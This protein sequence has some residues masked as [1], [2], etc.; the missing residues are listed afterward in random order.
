[1]TT[2]VGIDADLSNEAQQTV[3]TWFQIGWSNP[4]SIT[5]KLKN[6]ENIEGT[7]ASDRIVG[8]NTDNM[9]SGCDGND[10][11]NGG[12]GDDVIYTGSGKDVIL[13]GDGDDKI[14]VQHTT[15]TTARVGVGRYVYIRKNEGVNVY[16]SLAELQVISNGMNVSLGKTANLKNSGR[17]YGKIWQGANLVD[18]KTG[19]NVRTDGIFSSSSS[20]DGWIQVDLGSSIA[21]DAINIFGRSDSLASENGNYTVYVSDTDMAG[22]T[23]TQLKAMANVGFVNVANTVDWVTLQD[24]LSVTAGTAST[25]ML[26]DSNNASNALAATGRY[27]YIRKNA[28]V[29]DYLSLA[30]LEVMS[31][32]VNVAR[33]KTDF[34][35]KSGEFNSTNHAAKNVVDGKSSGSPS[36]DG[37]FASNAAG[38]GWIQVDLGLSTA[39]DAINIFG[40]TDSWASQNGNYTVYVSDTDMAGKTDAELKTMAN[41]AYYNQSLLQTNTTIFAAAM[42]ATSGTRGNFFTRYLISD[43]KNID[44][45]AGNDVVSYK[46]SGPVGMGI[47]A[48]LSPERQTV[49]TGFVNGVANALSVTDTL[50]SIE[51]IEG[52]DWNDKLLGS[53]Q[54]NKLYGAGGADWIDGGAGD[55]ELYTGTGADTVWGGS[56]DD[57]IRVQHT[58]LLV[59]KGRYVYIRKNDGV[60]NYLSLGELE[61]MSNGVNVALG[62][63]SNLQKSGEY[64]PTN[65]AA[66]NLVDGKSGGNGSVDGIFASNTAGGG[67]IQVDLGL[68]TAI[69]AINIFGRTDSWATQ[70]GNYTV[71]VSDTDMAG[72][73]DAELKTMANVGFY[74]ENKVISSTSLSVPLFTTVGTSVN[75]FRPFWSSLENKIIDGGEGSDTVSY[76]GMQNAV[77]M[78]ITANLSTA[79]QTVGVWRD[80]RNDTNSTSALVGKGRYVYI[81]KNEGV[82]DYLSLAELQVMSNGVN[83]ALGKT[84]NLQKSGEYNR[85]NHAAVNLVDGTTGGHTQWYSIF[86]SS[87][88]VGG[89]IQVDLGLSTAIDAIN[90]FGRTDSWASQNGNYTLYVSDTDMAGKT[91]AEV[92]AMVKVGYY[93]VDTQPSVL[94]LLNPLSVTNGTPMD[95]FFRDTVASGPTGGVLDSLRNI[96][97]IEGTEASDRLTGSDQSNKLYGL[98]GNDWIEGLDGND[99]IETG[100]GF[101][102]VVA[103]NGDDVIVVTHSRPQGDWNLATSLSS[104][105]STLTGYGGVSDMD[106][107]SI[108]MSLTRNGSNFKGE[109]LQELK[110]DTGVRTAWMGYF[111]A[112]TGSKTEGTT[113]AVKMTFRDKSGGGVEVSVLGAKSIGIMA[114]NGQLDW[115]T[116][117]R[118]TAVSTLSVTSLGISALGF[119]DDYKIINGGD[120]MD[121]VSYAKTIL[122]PNVGIWADL[123]LPQQTVKTWTQGGT[124]ASASA[125]DNLSGIEG[126]EGTE[127]NDY[128]KGNDRI[129]RLS[130]GSGNDSIDA[131][132]GADIIATGTGAD[133]VLAG[134]GDDIIYAEHAREITTWKV[135]TALSSSALTVLA[136]IGNVNDLFVSLG[137]FGFTADAKTFINGR[138]FLK[139][140]SQ[141][142]KAVVW[143]GSYDAS[144]QK[145]Y[146]VQIEFSDTVGG[147]VSAKVL[148]SK[149]VAGTEAAGASLDW[150][151]S[152]TVPMTAYTVSSIS[153]SGMGYFNDAKNIAGGAGTNTLD[154]IYSKTSRPA[155]V[156]ISANLALQK[157]D[158][159]YQN[160]KVMPGNIV[161]SLS[162][163]SNL[164]GTDAADILLGD[165]A[166]NELAGYGGDD[167][168]DGGAGNDQLSTGTGVDTVIGGLGDDVIFVI[169]RRSL[170]KWDVNSF[171]S[172]STPTTVT[173]YGFVKDINIIDSKFTLYGSSN[174]NQNAV[175]LKVDKSVYGQTTI[176]VGAFDGAFTLAVHI[177]LTDKLDSTGTKYVGGV[178]AVVLAAKSTLGDVTQTSF[179]WDT[180]GENKPIA[181]QSGQTGLNVSVS[182]F[183]GAGL[184][185]D[186]KNLQGG[187]GVDTVNYRSISTT[188]WVGVDADLSTES[189]QTVKTWY[190][191]NVSNATSVTDTLTGLE[192]FGGSDFDDK[193]VGSAAANKLWGYNGNDIISAGDG[194]D[195]VIT[196]TG[197]DTV[198]AGSGDDAIYVEHS[199][200][201]AIAKG[202]FVLIRKED[203]A[204]AL[205]V[206]GLNV[207]SNGR[208][209]AAGITLSASSGNWYQ[210][211]LGSSV[212]IEQI[213]VSF[214]SG[215]SAVGYKAYVSDTDMQSLA[216]SSQ[217]TIMTTANIAYSQM[218]TAS[219]SATLTTTF[220]NT[221]GSVDASPVGSRFIGS[222]SINGGAGEDFLSYR[223][224][225]DSNPRQLN[226]GIDA[227]L[228]GSKVNTWFEYATVNASSAVDTISN[229]ENIGGTEYADRLLGNAVGNKL[230]GYEGNDTLDGGGGDDYLM[231]GEGSDTYNINASF[232]KDVIYE[233]TSNTGDIDQVIFNNINYADLWFQKSGTDLMVS[234]LGS[235][236]VMGIKNWYASDAQVSAQAKIESFK[237]GKLT[238]STQVESLVTVMA[239]YAKPSAT[240]ASSTLTSAAKVAINTA[241]ANAWR[242]AA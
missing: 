166:A 6:I 65:H 80:T 231:G 147:G 43:A 75:F 45:G 239:Q 50:T 168:L 137:T 158:T 209:V 160:K 89:W 215:Q 99:Y 210:V 79:Q 117:A 236:N 181:L 223:Q 146:A 17:Y 208:D 222:K 42:T 184:F 55:D 201:A 149:Y 194:D 159:W 165:G 72:K 196:G 36:V 232:G 211:N 2:D 230:V 56:G 41:V 8:S 107:L 174:G 84:A 5:D 122:P 225:E 59:G 30:E 118:T 4:S 180:R 20:R 12:K 39:I 212:A 155:D 171:L 54:D 216:V 224:S 162:N 240:I 207:M 83:V 120:G 139:D 200:P 28:G 82:N 7:Q 96:E 126:I 234:Q 227:D 18:G 38:G 119:V 205:T 63:T 138:I 40:R 52:T 74:R 94:N 108:Q 198:D 85:T 106:F 121:L 49:K 77:G 34:L 195:V 47:D 64:N 109:L 169:H 183:V 128:L 242:T 131:G 218:L 57:V 114:Q 46:N 189:A 78:G 14:S 177:K 219:S 97:N 170:A 150:N 48:D 153:V 130:G 226:V 202:R 11:I 16:L 187:E 142:G 241:I 104:S 179:D 233:D 102:K 29:N 186:A 21:I 24:P 31:N 98:A 111:Q 221:P 26:P 135:S 93:K 100:T 229:I 154:Y 213:N 141:S 206:T 112:N 35:Q 101:D 148:R 172:T 69:D 151:T 81:R 163:I 27:V 62:K 145:T 73:T 1:M 66:K 103:G 113:Y 23:D 15:K 193:I 67:W 237:Q 152:G 116:D 134:D 217:S 220:L 58:N 173:T 90:I 87:T 68:S 191:Q 143:V 228:T 13:G 32:G 37:I 175:V 238:L 129:N 199:R 178:D 190:L 105:W 133:T 88:Y 115:E 127:G 9:L 25:F 132:A 22:K 76:K 182:N 33:G 3:K 44:G 197:A 156:G 60:N 110:A 188:G 61:V 70:N 125:V 214:V 71:Y 95:F 157:V 136:P 19:G 123:S 51:S 10:W 91:D 161:D 53:D 140:T 92:K 167:H 176:W 185:D 203:G 124:F 144:S 192:N 164:G 235:T 204:P 86:S